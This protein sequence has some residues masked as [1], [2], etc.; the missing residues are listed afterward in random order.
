MSIKATNTIPEVSLPAGASETLDLSLL[1]PIDPEQRAGGE[2]PRSPATFGS[3]AAE[4]PPRLV[5]RGESLQDINSACAGEA[6]K[7]IA[8]G[9]SR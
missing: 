3:L 1:T 7:L 5:I 6:F 4:T 2:P 9:S 8:S